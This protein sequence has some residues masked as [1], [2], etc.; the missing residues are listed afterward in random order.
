MRC[1]C[2]SRWR[3]GFSLRT[4]QAAEKHR[5]WGEFGRKHTSGAEVRVDSV[6]VMPAINGWVE[7]HPDQ[8]R[9]I[10]NPNFS[11][12]WKALIRFGYM[13]GLKPYPSRMLLSASFDLGFW[14]D[15][16]LLGLRELRGWLSTSRRN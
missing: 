4:E 7:T 1:C 10:L 15:L 2:G 6:G 11:A 5:V 3:G 8:P 13:Y 9:P 14:I 16:I 12:S